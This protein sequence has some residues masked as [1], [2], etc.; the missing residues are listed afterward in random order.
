M[1][2]E[3]LL[4]LGRPR[5]GAA[6]KRSTI[7]QTERPQQS[8]IEPGYLDELMD[9]KESCHGVR[10]RQPDCTRRTQG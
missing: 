5:K 7:D 4:N 10:R 9:A 6:V 3:V 8:A 2:D 1:V